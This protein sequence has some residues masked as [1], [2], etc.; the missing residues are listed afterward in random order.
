MSDMLSSM[1]ESYLKVGGNVIKEPTRRRRHLTLPGKVLEEA[2]TAN[3]DTEM[4]DVD[5]YVY[6][7][8]YRE[9]VEQNQKRSGLVG[10]M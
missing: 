6:D 2:Q 8:Y 5:D 4:M 10:L 9:S 3:N 1:V 7:I